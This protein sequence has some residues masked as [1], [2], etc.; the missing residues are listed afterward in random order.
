MKGK[1]DLHKSKSI[2][3]WI[4]SAAF[5]A[6]TLQGSRLPEQTVTTDQLIAQTAG[7]VGHRMGSGSDQDEYPPLPDSVFG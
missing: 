6:A 1:S 3:G 7:S 4:A 5:V 2:P